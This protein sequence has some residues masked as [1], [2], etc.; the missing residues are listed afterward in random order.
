M[1]KSWI[2]VVLVIVTLSGCTPKDDNKVTTMAAPQLTSSRF[3]GA[4]ATTTIM[5]P[6]QANDPIR[7]NMTAPDGQTPNSVLLSVVFVPSSNT[8]KAQSVNI[9]SGVSPNGILIA[10]FSTD[11]TNNA[12]IWC[13]FQIPGVP[14]GQYYVTSSLNTSIN[15]QPNVPESAA[16]AIYADGDITNPNSNSVLIVVQDD[17]VMNP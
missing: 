10:T 2:L 7:I 17:A 9:Y 5:P 1:K 11:G 16:E 3:R 15:S 6:Q 4:N 13:P 14:K 12:G 8:P